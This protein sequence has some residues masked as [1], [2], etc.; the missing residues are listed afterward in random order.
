VGRRACT[1][2]LHHLLPDLVIPM[3]RAWTGAF[4]KFHLPEWQDPSSQRRIFKIAY[5]QF[6]AVAHRT[7]PEQYVTH[8]G[9]RTSR[10]KILDNA[11]I[12]FCKVELGARPSPLEDVANQ[13][14][15]DVLDYPPSKD[16]ADSIFAAGH[17]YAP[18][19]RRLLEAAR[20]A[21]ADQHFLP[22]ADGYVGIE[23][24]LHAPVG[25][26]RSDATNYLGGIGD[27]LEDKANRS[28]L[29]HLDDLA[30][31]WLYRNDCQIKEVTYR[32]VESDEPG[33]TV[34]VRQLGS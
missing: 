12:G 31:V 33:Y 19:V 26:A 4:F 9:W 15:F 13:I 1:K 32:E 16:G 21:L 5:D 24:V 25:G 8:Q 14:S 10:A 6:A 11:L 20:Q 18:R 34:T 29:D 30:A 22:I 28:A 2:T 7:N 3:D 27:V 23:V 17:K